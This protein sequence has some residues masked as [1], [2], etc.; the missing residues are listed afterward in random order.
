M[1]RTRKH[2][3]YLVPPEAVKC[4]GCGGRRRVSVPVP[5]VIMHGREYPPGVAIMDCPR[6]EGKGWLP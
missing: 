5:A 6:C 4:H 3:L 2:V 1:T